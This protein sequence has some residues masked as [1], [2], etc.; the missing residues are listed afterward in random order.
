MS[1]G[2]EYGALSRAQR[3]QDI[4][5]LSPLTTEHFNFHPEQRQ[6]VVREYDRLSKLHYP[7]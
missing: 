2:L 7:G 5:L 4:S 3:L 1:I 6:K